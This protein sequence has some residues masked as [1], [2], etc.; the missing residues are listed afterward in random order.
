[1]HCSI[2]LN[3]DTEEIAAL[4]FRSTQ[5]DD[6]DFVRTELRGKTVIATFEAETL[7]SMRR[8]VDDFL[9]C[10]SVAERSRL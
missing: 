10:V 6:D 2:E 4:I 9:A 1:M 5:P 8:A 3:Y 7:E